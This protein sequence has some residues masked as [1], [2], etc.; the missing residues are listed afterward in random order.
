MPFSKIEF[1][2][3]GACKK[4]SGKI[5]DSGG[6]GGAGVVIVLYDM[7]GNP[8]PLTY[9]QSRKSEGFFRSSN[10]RMEL[11]AVLLAF[12]S[13]KKDSEITCPIHVLTDS[14]YVAKI[15]SRYSSEEHKGQASNLSAFGTDRRNIG[16]VSV[17][18]SN[19]WMTKDGLPAKNEDLIRELVP[20]F[21]KYDVY[22][23]K[24]KGHSSNQF[25][26]E[27][28]GLASSAA[29]HPTLHDV[30]WE[31][32]ENR[33]IAENKLKEEQFRNSFV[34]KTISVSDFD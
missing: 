32:Y 24:V 30:V 33:K 12:N 11:E 23:S 6:R 25:N 28:D 16:L 21:Q 10:N 31:E 7:H 18:L 9:E 34:V 4:D 3:D 29:F 13:I 22:I 27:A 20:Y 8:I 26:N 1:Y 17:F 14:E 19:G 15:F 2:T 5:H